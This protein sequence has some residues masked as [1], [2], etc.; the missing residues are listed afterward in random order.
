MFERKSMLTVSAVT[1]STCCGALLAACVLTVPLSADDKATALFDGKS[2]DG[3]NVLDSDKQWWTV[4][5]GAIVGGSLTENVT[6]NTFVASDESFQN[7]DLKLKIRIQG[8]DGFINSGVQI[9][10]VRVP[11]SSEMSGYQVDVGDG[12]WGKIYDESRRNK[13]VG[14]AA[15]L[16]AV[17][18]AIRPGDWN[19]YRILAEGRRIRSWIND[20]PALDYTEADQSIPLDGHIGFQ[21]HGG[22]KALVQVKDVT[23]ERLPPTLNAPTWADVQRSP[24]AKQPRHD[25]DKV[26]SQMDIQSP[27]RSPEEELR[28]FTVP[29]GFEVELVAAETDGVGK[30]VDVAFDAAGRMWTMTAL[31]YP[32]DANENAEASARLFAEGGCDKVLVFDQPFASPVPPPRVFAE[33]LVM[34]LSVLPYKDGAFIQYGQEIRFYRDTDGD[35]VADTHE[36]VLAGFGTQDSHLFPHQFTRAPGGWILTAQG[37]FNYSKVRRPDGQA[38]LSGASEIDFNQCKLARFR[39]TG[40][41]FELLTAGPNNIWGLTI[42]REGETWLQEANDL[43]CPIIPYEPGGHYPTGSPERLRPYQPLIPPT[44]SPPQMG[45]TGLSGLALADDTDGWPAPWGMK[46]AEADSPRIFYLANP[47]TSRIQSIAATRQGERYRYEKLPDFLI[48]EDPKFRP[49]AIQFGPDGCLYVTDWYN[50][51]ISHNE[52]PR[53]HPE[54]DKSRGRIWRIRHESQSRATPPNLKALPA[55][56]L[57]A[58]L[59]AANARI[60]DMAWQEIVD[61]NA[62]ELVPQLKQFVE[63]QRLSAD[64]RLGALWALEG[65]ASVPTSLLMA[66]ADSPNANLRHEAVRIAAAQSRPEAEFLAVAAVL[67]DDPAPNVRAALGDALRRVP[68]AGPE[69]I[70]LMLRLGKAPLPGESWESYDREF[71]RFLARWAMERNGQAVQDFLASPRGQQMPLENRVLATLA[72]EGAASATALAQLMPQ[73]QRPLTEEEIRTLANHFTEPAVGAAMVQLLNHP[74]SRDTTL[75]TLLTLRTNLDTTPLQGAIVSATRALWEQASSDEA[76]L[77][78]LQVTGAFRLREL[79][80][81]IAEFA[82]SPQIKPELKLAALRSL[83]ELGSQ[84]CETLAALAL[85]NDESQPVRDAALAALSDSPSEKA[86][87]TIGQLL[88]QLSFEQRASVIARMATSRNGSLAL[89]AAVE[90]ETIAP[91]DISPESLANMLALLPD[92]QAVKQLWNDVAG[93]V[94]RVLRLAGGKQDYVQSPITLSGPFTVECWVRLNPGI[95]N[96]DGILGHPDVL[97]M[98]FYD[99]TFRVWIAGRGDIA[100]ATRKMTPDTWTHLAVTR[101]AEGTIRIYVNGDLS[102]ESTERNTSPLAGLH[103]GRTAI[104]DRGTDGVLAEF[105]IWDVAR[106][107]NQIRDNFD[108]SFAG[109]ERPDGL[110]HYFAGTDWGTLSGN[111]QVQ[112]TLEGPLLLDA[113]Q[114]KRQTALFAKYRQLAE[115]PGDAAAGQVRFTKTC[116]VCH[117]HRGTGGKLGPALDGIGLTGTESLLRNILTPSAAMEGGYRTYQ[118]LTYSGQVIQGMLVSQDEHAVIL[119]QPEIADKRI[120]KSDIERAGFTSLS[121]MPLRLL[122]DL[123]P[124]D[125]SDL[126]AHLRSLKQSVTSVPSQ[127]GAE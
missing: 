94:R 55:E 61:R 112:P 18:D 123:Q 46:D 35:G 104:R 4:A 36:A 29:E 42:S 62:T 89:L 103:V 50:K 68:D 60:A 70:A 86:A 120:L 41:D 19:E 58:H 122:D 57:L 117:Q 8:T 100:I 93:Q 7:F 90:N 32:V 22:G 63:N 96:A 69:V 83:R 31:E 27:P 114:A 81:S 77:L 125:V 87:A 25:K 121:V 14:E 2:L 23:I 37:L 101:D 126:F 74:Q 45:G 64:K 16:Q 3:W 26:Q 65:L 107:P 15:N 24:P 115:Q 84:E 111:A 52:V 105:R 6:R 85:S 127:P 53:N 5:D 118:V 95:T 39:P 11:D 119:R 124:Q 78:A 44:L 92:H 38:F 116:L 80:A 59:G 73:L 106:S 1:W 34:P 9:R 109:E 21:V 20:V 40:S 17:N 72:L 82:S 66:L 76:R 48:S 67:M 71:E 30:F 91:E 56:A 10:S 99:E 33:G 88:V 98:N 113:E 102:T 75:R 47:I 108:R 51:I 110:A 12:W 97:S 49:V 28:G 54:R 43:G 79:D 13:V